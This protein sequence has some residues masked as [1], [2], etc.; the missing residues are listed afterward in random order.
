MMWYDETAPFTRLEWTILTQATGTA[1]I[2]TG[3]TCYHYTYTEPDAITLARW[4]Y[5]KE[6]ELYR[7]LALNLVATTGAFL[8]GLALGLRTI[9]QHSV[10]DPVQD[11]RRLHAMSALYVR[12]LCAVAA[13]RL[14][15]RCMVWRFTF[16]A[17]RRNENSLM[18]RPRCLGLT[19]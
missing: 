3:G 8:R 18:Y 19:W 13:I 10:S 7:L 14:S 1:Y 9:R 6:R 16:P 17:L 12:R 4:A 2:G 11:F 15:S 5:Q